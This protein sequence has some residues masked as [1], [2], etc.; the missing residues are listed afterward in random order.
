MLLNIQL[1]LNNFLLLISQIIIKMNQN[2]IKFEEEMYFY[3]L[4]LK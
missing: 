4:N 2:E 1:I 3:Y